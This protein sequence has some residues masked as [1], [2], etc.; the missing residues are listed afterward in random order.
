M[1]FIGLTPYLAIPVSHIIC[2]KMS[3]P[4]DKR[5]NSNE[6]T[7]VTKSNE[8]WGA[9]V[10]RH[11]SS[12]NSVREF[13]ESYRIGKSDEWS[14]GCVKFAVAFLRQNLDFT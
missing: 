13:I 11:W 9:N 10:H 6:F 5:G 3:L 12:C 2:I 14:E 1:S 8:G 4:G 7:I